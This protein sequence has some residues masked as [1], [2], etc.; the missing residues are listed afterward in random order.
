MPSL[1]S[2]TQHASAQ[3]TVTNSVPTV[4]DRVRDF[5]VARPGRVTRDDG[6]AIAAQFG[7]RVKFRIYGFAR[8]TEVP[9][10]LTV[11][12]SAGKATETILTAEAASNEGVF[13][14]TL[15]GFGDVCTALL[16]DLLADLRTATA[17]PTAH[18]RLTPDSPS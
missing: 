17:P 11:R 14:F 1:N 13:L 5:V 15:R 2:R 16:D 12:L 18:K 9:L 7:S 4:R 6:G 10:R 3:W 8:L